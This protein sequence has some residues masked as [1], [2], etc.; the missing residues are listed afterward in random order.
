[1][2]DDGLREVLD[3]RAMR[4]SLSVLVARQSRSALSMLRWVLTRPA[5]SPCN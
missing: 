2:Q 1:L 3:G 4:C 5:C